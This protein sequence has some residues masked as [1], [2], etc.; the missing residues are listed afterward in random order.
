[1]P[2]RH[3][4]TGGLGF[5]GQHLAS[6]LAAQGNEVII[7]DSAD[8]A[9][10]KLKEARLISGDI[11]DPTAL[12]QIGLGPEDIVYHLAARQF[13]GAVPWLGR[14]AW[15]AEVNTAG[16]DQVLRAME[17]GGSR[18]L[19]FFSTDMVYGRPQKF[20]IDTDH[21]RNPL[22]PYGRSKCAAEDLIASYRSRGGR[23]VVFRPRMIMG[24]GRL[25]ILAKL[26]R[27]IEHGLPVPMIG[28]G[29]NRYQMV[30]VHDCVRAAMHAVD[31]GL[32]A[33]PFNL[34]SSDPPRVRDLL[35]EL[36]VKS[37][38]RSRLL[39]TPA[40]PL[41]LLLA[42]L[43][44][45]G[46]TLLHREQYMIADADYVLDLSRTSG[47]LGFTPKDTDRDMLFAAYGEYLAS[48]RRA[49]C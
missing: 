28:D 46:L 15:F 7:F 48:K 36:I 22:G 31:R 11:R 1:M 45:I 19:V 14:D 13:H 5:L 2:A 34:G 20:P 10:A 25:G 3:V 18:S 30:S 4:I 41:K 40:G 26:F 33:G 42:T 44:G 38:S 6:A 32:P 9:D 29:A 43:D 16:T 8:A 24:A 27:L 12:Q 49:S 47:E 37:G 39:P 21:P 23:A 17:A 35:R